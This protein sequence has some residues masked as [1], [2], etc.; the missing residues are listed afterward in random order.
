[1]EMSSLELFYR[2]TELGDFLITMCLP[3]MA[4]RAWGVF[5]FVWNLSHL[6]LQWAVFTGHLITLSEQSSTMAW[7]TT[8]INLMTVI[9][10]TS[11][12][13]SRLPHLSPGKIHQGY[14]K[15]Q[16]Y[17]AF[18]S[19]MVIHWETR[20]NSSLNMVGFILLKLKKRM[21]FSTRSSSVRLSYWSSQ[22]TANQFS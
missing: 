3:F 14:S 15:L 6:T 17:L 12:S 1:M 2:N 5:H 11:K 21:M 22:S 18:A 4:P 20:Y 19:S 10:E 16:A 8:G 9:L 13:Y 7:R